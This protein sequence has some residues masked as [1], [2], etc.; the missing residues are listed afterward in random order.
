MR[1]TQSFEGQNIPKFPIIL[2]GPAIGIYGK[3]TF[4]AGM[5]TGFTGFP[6][7]P[8]LAAIKAGLPIGGVVPLTLADGKSQS[9]LYCLGMVEVES[10]HAIGVTVISPSED[11]LIGMDFLKLLN[12]KLIVDPI[13]KIAILTD[14]DI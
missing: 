1:I 5:D 9:F 13:N 12:L 14:E 2:S 8:L 3:H 4:D 11:I 6:S 7:V 10:K